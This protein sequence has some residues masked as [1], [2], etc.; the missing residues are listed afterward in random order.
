MATKP[1][2]RVNL[3]DIAA[4]AG[5]SIA[6]VSMA[7]SDHPRIAR[8]TKRRVRQ[9]AIEMGYGRGRGRAAAGQHKIEDVGYLLVGERLDGDAD[10]Y[11]LHTL[12]DSAGGAGARLLASAIDDRDDSP[13]LATRAIAWAPTGGVL[14]CGWV[15]PRLVGALNRAGVPYVVIGTMLGNEGPGGGVRGHLVTPDLEGM[16][17]FAASSLLRWG[18]RRI[19]FVCASAPPGLF[20]DAWRRGYFLALLDHQQTIDLALVY[21]ANKKLACCGEVVDQFLSLADAPTGFVVPD[22]HVAAMFHHAMNRR[23]RSLDSRS[24]IMASF[25][26][27]SEKYGLEG[28]PF[29]SCDPRMVASVAFRHLRQIRIEPLPCPAQ[30][31]LPFLTFHFPPSGDPSL[32]PA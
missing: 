9:L 1:A 14:L 26:S 16:G 31:T 12:M 4:R 30:I 23:G 32:G 2:K 18:H 28:F 5:A 10:A 20:N 8:E 19:A 13:A 3:K 11:L 6:A 15:G 21:V 24:I 17:R 7:L 22:L 25:P 27:L 29:L